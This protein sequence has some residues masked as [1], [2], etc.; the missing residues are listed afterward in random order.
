MSETVTTLDRHDR[1]AVLAVS[2]LSIIA[3][4]LT[5]VGLAVAVSDHL[6][7]DAEGLV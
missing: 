4:A 5:L 6:Q 3:L 2:W 1:R 7:K